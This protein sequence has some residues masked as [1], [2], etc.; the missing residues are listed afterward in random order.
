[1]I[2]LYRHVIEKQ[3][4]YWELYTAQDNKVPEIVSKVFAAYISDTPGQI[5]KEN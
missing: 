4:V 2:Q 3:I 5:S 1:M